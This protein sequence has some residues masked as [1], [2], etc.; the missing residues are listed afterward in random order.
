MF[1]KGDTIEVSWT[2]SEKKLVF[3]RRHSIEKC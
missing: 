1:S 3:S 2:P